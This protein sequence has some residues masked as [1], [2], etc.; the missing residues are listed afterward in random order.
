MRPNWFLSLP[1][2]ITSG[3]IGV[4]TD[5]AAQD[6]AAAEVADRDGTFL[7]TVHLR[8]TP[9]GF[10]RINIALN[11]LPEGGYGIHLHETGDCSADDFSSADGHIADGRSHGVGVDGGPH[12]GDLPN[13][14]VPGSETVNVEHFTQMLDLESMIF[15]EDG[16]A[17][18]VHSEEDD[19]V[20]Q[21]SG[22]AGD[23]MACGDFVRRVDEG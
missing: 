11:G 2:I 18:I 19:Y 22:D 16:A 12:P 7:G 23:R 1:L 6:R 13:L 5:A 9:S 17:F 21:P 20:S 15:D 4:A 8:E 3:L 14:I 10:V